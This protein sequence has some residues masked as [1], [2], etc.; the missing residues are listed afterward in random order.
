[1]KIAKFIRCFCKST[2]QA[3]EVP[4]TLP[5]GLPKNFLSFYRISDTFVLFFYIHC[6]FL[7]LFNGRLRAGYGSA[8]RRQSSFFSFNAINFLYKH[9]LLPSE[10]VYFLIE[11]GSLI[12]NNCLPVHGNH[13][14]GSLNPYWLIRLQKCLYQNNLKCHGHSKQITCGIHHASFE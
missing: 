4:R 6:V 1:M 2:S 12:L 7:N 14:T 10:T 5:S 11:T 3:F 8:C 13:S 9:G